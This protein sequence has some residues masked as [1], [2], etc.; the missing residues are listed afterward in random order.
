M[1]YTGGWESVIDKPRNGVPTGNK[2]VYIH[3][4]KSSCSACGSRI[5][6]RSERAPKQND[7]SYR[8]VVLQLN[9][10]SNHCNLSRTQCFL[11]E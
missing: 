11:N 7:Y 4:A 8:S 2:N 5:G 6:Q 10:K 9:E 1:E 3:M